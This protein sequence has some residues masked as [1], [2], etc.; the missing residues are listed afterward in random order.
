MLW[1]VDIRFLWAIPIK[2]LEK[3][4]DKNM[5]KRCFSRRRG[6]WQRPQL[7]GLI[8]LLL[9]STF[10]SPA[11]ANRFPSMAGALGSMDVKA[12][13]PPPVWGIADTHQ[14][15]FANLGFGGLM[16]W[17]DVFNT[18]D[19]LAKALPWSDFMPGRYGD[20]INF[21]GN[22]RS[23]DTAVPSFGYPNV[24]A[25]CPPGTGTILNPCRGFAIHGMGGVRDMINFF[26]SGN[27][28]HLVGGYP[29]FDGYPRWDTYTGQ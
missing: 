2:T 14:H 6:V 18:E 24:P 20:V 19:N 13:A 8:V 11:F 27:L 23:V 3:E 26:L 21:Q 22:S 16:I 17:G 4:G 10:V 15:Q 7:I 28:G 9:T 5:S 29:Q 25:N 12:E 1:L